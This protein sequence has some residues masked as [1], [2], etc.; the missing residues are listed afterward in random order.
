LNGHDRKLFIA[1]NSAGLAFVSS[2]VLWSYQRLG[3]LDSNIVLGGWDAPFYLWHAKT[4]LTYGS[5][6]FMNRITYPMLYPQFLAGIGY[7]S[8]NVAWSDRILPEIMAAILLGLYSFF[9]FRVTGN[10]H[11]AGLAA[12]LTGMSPGFLWMVGEYHRTS[13]AL[14]FAWI[15]FTIAINPQ[16]HDSIRRQLILLS[17]FFLAAFTEFEV[18]VVMGVT[19]LLCSAVWK[20]KKS[21]LLCG[22]FSLL[23]IVALQLLFPTFYSV[24]YLNLESETFVIQRPWIYQDL[25][26]WSIGAVAL[27]PLVLIGVYSLAKAARR[28][29]NRESVLVSL[30]MLT[31]LLPALAISQTTLNAIGVRAIMVIPVPVLVALGIG[32]S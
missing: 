15:G 8:G 12:V 23:P 6:Y 26:F 14:I 11:T 10:I 19:L 24:H 18:F 7:L 27:L 1:Y 5:V 25:T 9:T 28:A 3:L 31:L 17:L 4:I 20:N 29:T 22:V 32:Y 2:V 21:F 13:L 16:W 30:F